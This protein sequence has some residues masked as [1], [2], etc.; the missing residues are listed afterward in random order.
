MRLKKMGLLDAYALPLY[1]A[2]ILLP[3]VLVPLSD[4]HSELRRMANLTV[5]N[6]PG[7]KDKLY[8]KGAELELSYIASILQPG[9][10][11]NITIVNYAG[12]AQVGVISCPDILPDIDGLAGRIPEEPD[13]LLKWVGSR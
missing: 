8:L 4:E 13:D 7:T 2:T 1:A 3:T 6:V 9:S 10:G 5:S 12:H 11:L